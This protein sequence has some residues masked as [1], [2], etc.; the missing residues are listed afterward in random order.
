MTAKPEPRVYKILITNKPKQIE[1]EATGS[2]FPLYGASEEKLII[3][4]L[5]AKKI[6]L[7]PRDLGCLEI[8][9]NTFRN[10]YDVQICSLWEYA[11]P[12]GTTLY[13]YR[14]VV[15]IKARIRSDRF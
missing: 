8:F 5:T 3:T 9:N 10:I 7:S 13:G 12:Q 4:G 6:Q 2:V 14:L 1:F 15:A 11:D